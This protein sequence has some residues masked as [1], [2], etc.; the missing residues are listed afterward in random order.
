MKTLIAKK[1]IVVVLIILIFLLWIARIIPS[2]LCILTATRYVNDK[3]TDRDFKY[4][5]IEYSSA[6]GEYFVHFVDR[7]GKRIAIMTSPFR[8]SFDPLNLPN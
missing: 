4:N 5:F 2:G 3:Y 7:D 8:V 1:F 6:H